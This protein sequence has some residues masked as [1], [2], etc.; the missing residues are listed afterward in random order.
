MK[1]MIIGKKVGMT[2][3]ITEDGTIEPVTVINVGPVTVIDVLTQEKNGYSAIK[4]GFESIEVKKLNKPEMG[5]Y[6]KNNLEPKKYIKEFR[7]DN[8]GEYTIGQEISIDQFKVS[9]TVNVQGKS[10]G[11][12]FSGTIKRWNFSRGPMSHGSKSHRIPGS[13][14]GGTSPGRVIKGK[15]MAGQYGNET[16]TVKNLKIAKVDSEKSLIYLVGAVPGKRDNVIV[17]TK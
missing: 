5:F 4:V 6:K 14:G 10:S 2:Q 17:I 7:L 15:K 12:G 8:S 11:C 16:V 1:K 9:E 13:I 3:L